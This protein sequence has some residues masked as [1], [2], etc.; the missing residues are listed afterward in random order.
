MDLIEKLNKIFIGKHQNLIQG[1]KSIVKQIEKNPSFLKSAANTSQTCLEFNETPKGKS[2]IDINPICNFK[3]KLKT[4]HKNTH[5]VD[6]KSIK[7]KFKMKKK[8]LAVV[9]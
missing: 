8:I 7:Q 1:L 9:Q 2:Y 6:A 3:R 5:T 4:T